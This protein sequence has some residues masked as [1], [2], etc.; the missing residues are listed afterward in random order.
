MARFKFEFWLDAKK[1]D[2]LL[3]MEDIDGLKRNRLFSKTIRDGI[4]LIMDL[5]RG[6]LD[7][8]LE[9]F[10]QFK[11]RICDEN[12]SGGGGDNDLHTKI[13]RLESMMLQQ[14]EP[15]GILMSARQNATGGPKKIGLGA[16]D[17]PRI[18]DDDEDTLVVRKDT[19]THAS[20]NFLRAMMALQGEE[21]HF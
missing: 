6:N 20:E 3:L 15:G 12:A 8:L 7:V 5:R 21:A 10:P 4:R 16:L 9:L 14:A 19:S 11:S 13:D 1:D 18:D 2:E 17:A